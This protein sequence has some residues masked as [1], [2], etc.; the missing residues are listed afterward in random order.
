M[1]FFHIVD[2]P[3]FEQ[4]YVR[5]SSRFEDGDWPVKTL[6]KIW[7]HDLHL[8]CQM[9]A[10]S[11]G[12]VLLWTNMQ[13]QIRQN[14]ISD[15]LSLLTSSIKREIIGIFT[16]YPCR[17]AKKM[18]IKKRCA[19]KVVWPHYSLPSPCSDL[20]IRIDIFLCWRHV[21]FYIGVGRG[22]ICTIGGFKITRN[23]PELLRDKGLQ[24]KGKIFSSSVN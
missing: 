10:N 22:K 4:W 8:L 20:R 14:N 12:G 18:Y 11:P 16:F 17:T 1:R 2:S 23:L 24:V 21:Y 19:G 13:L 6:L 15:L 9:W 3:F 5:T 7:M